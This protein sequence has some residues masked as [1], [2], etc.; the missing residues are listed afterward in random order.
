V[1]VTNTGSAPAEDIEL[2]GSGP[3]GWKIAFEPKA[4]DKIAPNENKEVQALITPPARAIAGDY[5]ANLRASS[6]SESATADFRVT[7]GTSTIWGVVALGIVGIA[8][9]ILV[10]AVW[11]FG[12]R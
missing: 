11:R 2:S 3:T 8:L 9:L 6:R 7:L 4:V 5:S 12:R 1:V 10:G